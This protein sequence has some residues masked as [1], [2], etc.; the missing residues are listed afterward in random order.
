VDLH[1]TAAGI[2]TYTTVDGVGTGALPQLSQ[3]PGSYVGA[4]RTSG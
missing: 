1:A 4:D 3:V 2:V